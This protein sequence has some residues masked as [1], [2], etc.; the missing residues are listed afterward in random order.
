[1]KQQAKFKAV[2]GSKKLGTAYKIT[3]EDK[4]Y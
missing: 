4:K 1:V 3:R 2:T